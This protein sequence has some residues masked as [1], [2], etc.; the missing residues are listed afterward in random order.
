M[1]YTGQSLLRVYLKGALVLLFLACV[2]CG[3][4]AVAQKN[5]IGF[6]LGAFNY[7]GDLARKIKAKNFQPGLTFHYRRNISEAVSLRA[8]FTGGW[9]YGDDNP[10]FDALAQA[11]DTS[12]SKGV[13]ELSTVMEYHFLDFRK[14]INILRWTPYFFMGA[15]V[16]FFGQSEEKTEE[17]SNV[18]LVVPFGLGF[19]YIINPKWQ[20]ALEGGVRKTFFDYIDNVSGSDINVKNYKYGNQYDKDW[21]YFLGVTLNYTFYTI[22]CPYKFN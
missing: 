11:R 18:Q 15:G 12:F 13:V 4:D 6:G 9:L 10:P 7:T 2:F 19:K 5:E 21:Y 17:Y 20:L 1:I 8:G 16:A 3:N 14:N 22:P